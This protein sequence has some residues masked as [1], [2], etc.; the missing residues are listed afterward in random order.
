MAGGHQHIVARLGGF[1]PLPRRIAQR[2]ADARL[3]LDGEGAGAH[4][5]GDTIHP[6]YPVQILLRRWGKVVRFRPDQRRHGAKSQ[7]RQND[8][9]YIASHGVLVSHGVLRSLWVDG[10]NRLFL[11]H[12]FNGTSHGNPLSIPGNPRQEGAHSS[13]RSRIIHD[14]HPCF[15]SRWHIG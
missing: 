4:L 2:D 9:F 14:R 12:D 6:E 8:A 5:T 15:R 10:P 11:R 1:R 7:H 13:S 3:I